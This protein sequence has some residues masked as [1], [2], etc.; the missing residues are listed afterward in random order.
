M[1]SAVRARPPLRLRALWLAAAVLPGLACGGPGASPVS[2]SGT[3]Y[4]VRGEIE[5]LP[6]PATSGSA[7]EIWIRHESVPEF[8]NSAGEVV[9]MESMTMPF[10]LAADASV[11]GLQ[12][13]DRVAF[14]L[15]VDWQ[16]KGAPAE[17]SGLRKLASGTA[18]EFDAPADAN[19]P[20]A[21]DDGASG[22]PG[23]T[24]K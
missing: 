5:R 3:T 8:E 9:G 14:E 12:V 6:D 23:D 19:A 13:G 22:Q 17:V 7:R 20:A 16:G 11:E 10:Q 1:T 24:P 15:R 2:P 18:L 21:A 4:A